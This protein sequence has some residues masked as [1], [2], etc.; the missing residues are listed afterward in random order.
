MKTEP[1][2]SLSA[3]GERES[4]HREVYTA[5]DVAALLRVSRRTV[6]RLRSRG[7][8]PAPV[9]IGGNIVRWRGTDIRDFLGTLRPRKPRRKR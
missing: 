5:S 8:L 7:I 6:F 2:D 1:S 3:V 9:E 4:A